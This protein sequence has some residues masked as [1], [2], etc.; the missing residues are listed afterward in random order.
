MCD[1]KKKTECNGLCCCAGI[2][3]L[4]GKV[5]LVTGG[6]QG[7]GR[8]V[9]QSLLQ[10]SAKVSTARSAFTALAS[11][12]W[13]WN[14]SLTL[15]FKCRTKLFLSNTWQNTTESPVLKL[16]HSWLDFICTVQTQLLSSLLH[17]SDYCVH[18]CC[19]SIDSTWMDWWHQHCFS[20]LNQFNMSLLH[21]ICFL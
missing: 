2:M 16:P 12:L 7:I 21:Y 8:A 3:S 5:A 9:V 6:A 1:R 19:A 11:E 10:S 20:V 17:L 15:H 14:C 18:V 13:G 4:N